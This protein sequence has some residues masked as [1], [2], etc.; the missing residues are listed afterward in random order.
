[1]INKKNKKKKKKKCY[2]YSQLNT[3]KYLHSDVALP[4]RVCIYIY[5]FSFSSFESRDERGVILKK[6]KKKKNGRGEHSRLVE[7]GSAT[8]ERV[9][10]TERET[11]DWSSGEIDGR[12]LE[13]PFLRSFPLP[14]VSLNL[15][16]FRS[17]VLIG[18]S[19]FRSA[20][21]T[22]ASRSGRSLSPLASPSL[23]P[24]ASGFFPSPLLA[25][26]SGGEGR[27]RW[28]DEILGENHISS[29]RR[30]G[31]LVTSARRLGFECRRWVAFGQRW[32]GEG[33]WRSAREEMRRGEKKN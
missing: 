14:S 23:S 15:S 11:A 20:V 10:E 7:R 13:S 12:R 26:L 21:L 17:A 31:G 24:P 30:L 19:L 4:H 22:G 16:L 25:A 32:E 8:G 6:K 28:R 5:I 1:M 29:R 33:R 18:A 3:P 9:P 2:T 27:W